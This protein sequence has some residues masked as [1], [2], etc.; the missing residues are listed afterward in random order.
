MKMN[1]RFIDSARLCATWSKD[2]STKVGAVLVRG[3]A[4]LASG[5]NCFPK[6]HDTKPEHYTNREYK[7]KHIVHAEINVVQQAMKY[8]RTGSIL[9]SS[10]YTNFP[11]CP[12]CMEVLGVHGVLRV[13]QP[14]LEDTEGFA[15]RSPEWIK[16]WSD[17]L[18]ESADIANALHI[19]VVE[20][21]YGQ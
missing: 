12:D 2:P 4:A 16:E 5:H 8:C 6:G 17:R 14:R 13:F 1:K 15:N 11:V 20:Y 21:T 3:K 18:I 10:M 19:D 9:G 7:L